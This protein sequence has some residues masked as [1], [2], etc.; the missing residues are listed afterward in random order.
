MYA[1]AMQF[2]REVKRGASED[3]FQG[4][5][6]IDEIDYTASISR[7][8]VRSV[9]QDGGWLR[10]QDMTATIRKTLLS[11]P[12]LPHA[13]VTDLSDGASFRFRDSSGDGPGEIAWVLNCRRIV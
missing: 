7:G 4:V 10:V 2:S 1:A 6:R 8:I 3:A 9:K 5:V 11:A 13:E 12:P